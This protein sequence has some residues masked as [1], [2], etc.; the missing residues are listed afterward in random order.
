MVE[1]Y[2][3]YVVR[4][5]VELTVEDYPELQG[6]TEEEM[7]EYI[8]SNWSEMKST[9]DEYYESLYDECSQGEIVRD[10]ITDETYECKFN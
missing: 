9:D 1:S 3:T 8:S 5:S 4:E 6:M 7:Q 2:H 10:K